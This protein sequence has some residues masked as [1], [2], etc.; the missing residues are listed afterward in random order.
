[1]LLA[2]ASVVY[3]PVADAISHALS[4][5]APLVL[6]SMSA[7]VS[8]ETQPLVMDVASVA[9]EAADNATDGLWSAT[10]GLPDD[11]LPE[12]P[13][14][15]ALLLAFLFLISTYAQRGLSAWHNRMHHL[16]RSACACT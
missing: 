14:D 7:S 3:C 10:L 9:S 16:S 15:G 8:L 2:T 6:D 13:P 5:G 11:K 1:M 12:V 4:A